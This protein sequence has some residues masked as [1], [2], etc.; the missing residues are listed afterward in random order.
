MVWSSSAII[1]T[2]TKLNLIQ[3]KSPVP[4]AWASSHFSP[5][6][7]IPSPSAP[8][9]A[10]AASHRHV[11]LRRGSPGSH[12]AHLRRPTRLRALPHHHQRRRL[13]GRR[14]RRAWS[15]VFDRATLTIGAA[16]GEIRAAQY[17]YDLAAPA[18]ARASASGAS[19]EGINLN[20]RAAT[21]DLIEGSLSVLRASSMLRGATSSNLRE[22]GSSYLDAAA[23]MLRASETPGDSALCHFR[24]SASAIGAA[25]AA[26]RAALVALSDDYPLTNSSGA[27]SGDDSDLIRIINSELESAL[28]SDDHRKV[29]NILTE[30]PFEMGDKG[31]AGL[32]FTRNF[33]DEEIEVML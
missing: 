2:W 30:F 11:P 4:G 17:F 31:S 19:R 9:S 22:A 32:T 12:G 16:E 26:F 8:A 5:L 28:R 13:S 3:H 18:L 7:S 20:V 25:E 1:A 6:P 29:D 23:S 24:A 33:H 15:N 10:D 27:S 21:S 14:A